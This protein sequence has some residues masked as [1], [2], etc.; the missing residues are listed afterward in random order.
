[1]Q[2]NIEPSARFIQAFNA[3]I[4]NFTGSIS[5][6]FKAPNCFTFVAD[7][8]FLPNQHGTYRSGQKQPELDLS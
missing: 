4:P 2:R 5:Q 6:C 8:E 3:V 1:M 7:A